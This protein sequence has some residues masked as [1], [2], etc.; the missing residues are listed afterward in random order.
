MVSILDALS[1]FHNLGI[2]HRDI[3]PHNIM[4]SDKI[5]LIDFGLARK[6]KLPLVFPTSGTAG[7]MA[8]EIINYS[9]DN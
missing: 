8:P 9:K 7:Y 5:I 4:L 1:Y 2:M 6:I 3:N